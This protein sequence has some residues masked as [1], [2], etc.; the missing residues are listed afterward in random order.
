MTTTRYDLDILELAA[1]REQL[2]A[3]LATPLGRTAVAELAPLADAAA[4]NRA[5]RR[6]APGEPVDGG[7]VC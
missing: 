1:V 7:E 2:V 6:P 5:Q 3:R 4:A